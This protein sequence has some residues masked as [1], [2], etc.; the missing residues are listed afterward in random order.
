[1]SN[2]ESYPA[3]HNPHNPSTPRRLTRREQDKMIAGVC[4]GAA[5]HFGIDVTVVRLLMV[6]ATVFTGGAGILL[7][8]A[9]WWLMPR[10]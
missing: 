3:P 2:Y 4:S 7:Y 8:L 10:G 5:A 1:M 6:A 9:G